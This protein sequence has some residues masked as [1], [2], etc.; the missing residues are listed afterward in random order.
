MRPALAPWPRI[1]DKVARNVA[2]ARFHRQCLSQTCPTG[3][4]LRKKIRAPRL[5]GASSG[6]SLFSFFQPP[7]RRDLGQKNKDEPEEAPPSRGA[8][9]FF[10]RQVPVGHVC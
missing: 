3:T 9:I 10:R 4:C 5:G 8:R 7:A 6:S 1:S 2:S